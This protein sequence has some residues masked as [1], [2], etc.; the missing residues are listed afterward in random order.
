ME[1]VPAP[2]GEA[3]DRAGRDGARTPMQWRD[4]AGGGFTS[5]EPWL[6]I[7]DT[8][9]VNV[10]DQADDSDSLFSLYRRLIAERA[11]SPA[12]TGGSYRGLDTAPQSGVFAYVRE[13]GTERL[14]IAIECAGR[15]GSHDLSAAAR[16]RL[17]S[18]GTLR[19]STAPD[20]TAAERV[21]LAAVPLASN[22]GL[23]IAI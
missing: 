16:G 21:D 3:M 10:A 6:R 22:E 7:G 23:I 1:D 18:Q 14:L 8:S 9:S 17:P 19:L 11:A 2:E 12:L 5:G 4:E 15:S 20:R 13:S